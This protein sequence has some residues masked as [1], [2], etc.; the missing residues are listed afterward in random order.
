[1]NGNHCVR[2]RGALAKVGW[3]RSS[4][5][6]KSVHSLA[7][8]ISLKMECDAALFEVRFSYMFSSWMY[9]ITFVTCMSYDKIHLQ[10]DSEGISLANSINQ[11]LPGTVRGKR[12][13]WWE[14]FCHET[15]FNVTNLFLNLNGMDGASEKKESTSSSLSPVS[16]AFP[17]LKQ[18]CTHAC[19]CL[20]MHK[21]I[22]HEHLV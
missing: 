16:S 17:Y 19:T 1:M 4:R 5:T 7:T 13:G 3:Q 2:D 18:T 11:N 12:D 14:V 8:V 22:A 10:V 15:Y 20:H 9:R 21:L 6:D